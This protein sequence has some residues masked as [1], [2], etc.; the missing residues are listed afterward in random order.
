MFF[1]FVF[2][3]LLWNDR[4]MSHFVPS[5]I[6]RRIPRQCL[7]CLLIVFIYIIGRCVIWRYSV[8]LSL[9]SI[10]GRGETQSL[11]E[12]VVVS[13]FFFLCLSLAFSFVYDFR[14]F[15]SRVELSASV[16]VDVASN[17]ESR[18][19]TTSLTDE[20]INQM[21]K[22]SS[23]SFHE[24]ENKIDKKIYIHIH[25]GTAIIPRRFRG[26]FC[27]T[28][29]HDG[30]RKRRQK[31]ATRRKKPSFDMNRFLP[32]EKSQ[33]S[34]EPRSPQS[35]AQSKPP[36]THIHIY[37]YEYNFGKTLKKW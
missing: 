13:L 19:A 4:K 3:F 25:P 14:Q 20:E 1:F 23:W 31:E 12:S 30:D 17:E 34:N 6:P 21:D 36:F 29:R 9:S 2:F 11:L 37:I 24:L 26:G 35:C 16:N 10:K 32:P 7:P 22:L 5:G 15:P 8:S 28:T 33:S 27:R 18:R